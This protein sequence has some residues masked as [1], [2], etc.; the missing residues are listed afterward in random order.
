[1]KE[2]TRFGALGAVLAAAGSAVGLG[3]IWKFPYMTGENGGGAFLLIYL[4]CILLFGIPILSAEF[5]AGRRGYGRWRWLEPAALLSATIFCGFYFVITGWCFHYLIL[6]IT[7]ATS[8][9]SPAALSEVFGGVTGEVV[10][11]C[12][13]IV[14]AVLITALITVAG[15]KSGIERASKILMP[16]LFIILIALIIY[17]LTLPGHREG[18][19]FLFAP[20]FSKITPTLII[21]ALGQ[22]FFT[23][24]LG[25]AVMANYASFMEPS[26]N[27][28]RTAVHVAGLDTIVAILA[29]LAIFPAVF[30]L[31]ID[32]TQGP[33]L[34]FVT[35]PSAFNH[36]AGGYWLQI[37]FFLL[38]VIAAVT[39]TISI[40][41]TQTDWLETHTRLSRRWATFIAALTDLLLALFCSLSLTNS[42]ADYLTIAGM[43]IYDAADWLVSKILFPAGGLLFSLYVGWI[44]DPADV[45]KELSLGGHRAI[46]KTLLVLIR[47]VI[48]VVLILI[49]IVGFLG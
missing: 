35:L 23:L 32:P 7:G 2:K 5:Y 46:G 19:R 34:V 8:A 40:V 20:D 41:Q 31:G 26:Q 13:C 47:Y 25:M 15:I 18:L 22:C 39:T 3:N 37:L 27:L 38:M 12:L 48:P 45:V 11:P 4:V 16:L 9:L 28:T 29:G 21:N 43:S 49:V 24:S 30:S 1:M 17:G 10:M 6:S 44:C 36:I 14:L 42:C 33:E